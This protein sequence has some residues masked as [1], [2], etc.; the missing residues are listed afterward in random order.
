[1]LLLRV[2]VRTGSRNLVDFLQRLLPGALDP[3]HPPA[4][5]RGRDLC[6]I[7]QAEIEWSDLVGGEDLLDLLGGVG[8]GRGA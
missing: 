1:M 7:F 8:C 3:P 4:E 2:R 5:V 6:E